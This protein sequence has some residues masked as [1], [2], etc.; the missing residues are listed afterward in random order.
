MKTMKAEFSLSNLFV[1]ILILS[2]LSIVQ[3]KSLFA[4]DGH[5]G[6]TI[7]PM[8]AE[9]QSEGARIVSKFEY[10]PIE[11]TPPKPERLVLDNG[12]ILYLLEDH[13]LPIFRITARFKTGAVYEPEEKGLQ[14]W[15]AT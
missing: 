6:Q 4:Y 7:E 5:G 12:M 3:A 15:L 10:K 13:D 8:A 2:S 9:P 14:I 1:L 11:F